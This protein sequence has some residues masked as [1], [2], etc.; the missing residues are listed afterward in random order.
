MLSKSMQ[1]VMNKSFFRC[2]MISAQHCAQS[3]RQ[4]SFTSKFEKAGRDVGDQQNNDIGIDIASIDVINK[5]LKRMRNELNEKDKTISVLQNKLNRLESDRSPKMHIVGFPDIH[6]VQVENKNDATQD[7]G[8]QKQFK[9]T[10]SGTSNYWSTYGIFTIDQDSSYYPIKVNIHSNPN[11]SQFARD[12]Y[13]FIGRGE[14]DHTGIWMPLHKKPFQY[15]FK[16][17]KTKQIF[18][19]DINDDLIKEIKDKKYNAIKM[20]IIDYG[21]DH[22]IHINELSVFVEKI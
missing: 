2:N 3:M 15:F 14:D 5:E 12:I 16:T 8:P 1:K 9:F 19:F 4:F 6:M 21:K 22:H 10:A 13:F 17:N 7:N 18:N 20:K 11:Y